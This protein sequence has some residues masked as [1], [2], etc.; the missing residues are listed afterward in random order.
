MIKSLI[1][2]FRSHKLASLLNISGL[3]LA[4]IGV[5]ILF[6][7]INFIGSFNSGIGGYENIYRIYPYGIFQDNDWSYTLPRPFIEKLKDCPQ[8]ENAGYTAKGNDLELE[9]EGS[10]VT[11]QGCNASENFLLF[12]NAERI[13]GDLTLKPTI[14]CVIPASLS[15]KYFGTVYSV[16]KQV[17][18]KSNGMMITVTG[19]YKDFPANCSIENAMYSTLG[20]MNIDNYNNWNYDAYVRLVPDADVKTTENTIKKTFLKLLRGNLGY[21]S[22]DA[23][24]RSE[25]DKGIKEAEV[26]YRFD[27]IPL[28]ETYLNGHDPITDKGNKT[29]FFLQK[30]AVALLLIIV[31]INFTNFTMAQ[32]PT[33][34]RGINTRRVMGESIMALRLQLIGEGV[35]VCFIAFIASLLVVYCLSLWGEIGNYVLGSISLCDNVGVVL[36]LFV[37]SVTV[38]IFASFYSARYITSFQPALALRGSA[39]LSPHGKSLRQFLIGLQLALSFMLVIFISAIYCQTSYINS[40]DY[41]YRKDALLFG[42]LKGIPSE[43]KEALRSELEKINGVEAVSFSSNP[44]GIWDSS[45]T[46]KRRNDDVEHS[47]SSFP[48]DWKLLRTLGI[49]VVEGR[50]FKDSDKTV[51]IVNE[52]FKK[53]YPDIELEKPLND[54]DA[55]LVGICQNFRAFTTRIDNNNLPVAFI[56]YGYDRENYWVSDVRVLYT[57]IG[58]N[59]NKMEIRRKINKVIEPFA[60]DGTPPELKFLDECMEEAYHDELR[61]KVQMEASTSLAFFITLIGVFCL[62]MFETEYR[63]KEIGIRKV[64]GSSVNEVLSLFAIRYTVPLLISFAIAAPAGFFLCEKWLQNFAEHTPIHWWIFPLSFFFVSA[65]VLLTVVV[66]SWRVAT[67]NPI[68]SIKTE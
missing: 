56:C 36:L 67:A 34:L 27:L 17:K 38:G 37:I 32:A 40:S 68:E 51:Y 54:G 16:G 24:Q 28:S 64:M 23:A 21:E 20:D 41:G 61:F 52:A 4:F 29:T 44:F 53:K 22:Q 63:R 26:K 46:W 13:D 14:S 47:F 10:I 7:Q 45:M 2:V 49:E 6:T 33:R 58:A 66:Q 12:A 62:T 55:P 25:I 42:N 31:L 9:K 57:R 1:H 59:T 50:D 48:A 8:I 65:I 5:Y 18:R 43:K 60:T 30:F 11:C 39:G 3:T 19:V 35:T 15:L